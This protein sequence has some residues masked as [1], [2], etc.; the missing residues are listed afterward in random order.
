LSAVLEAFSAREV[1]EGVP[2]PPNPLRRQLADEADRRR[3]AWREL[4][5]GDR[6]VVDG[7]EVEV[8]HPVAPD[9]ERQRVRNDDSLVLRLR[10]GAAEVLLTGDVGAAVERGL[11]PDAAADSD[12]YRVVKLAHHGSQSSTSEV[13]LDA[14]APAIAIASLGRNNPFGHPS[15]EVVARLASRGIPLIRTDRDGAVMVE[16]DGREV[17]VSTWAGRVWRSVARRRPRPA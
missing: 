8:L 6:L 13:F 16:T 15:R 12:T 4:R 9:W 10:F 11:L 17:R 1:W 2:V 7:V 3:L 14:Y 5:R